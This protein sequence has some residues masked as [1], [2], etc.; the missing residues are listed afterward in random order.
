[1]SREEFE[2][3]PLDQ[4]IALAVEGINE[5]R[6]RE[7][8]SPLTLTARACARAELGRDT[9]VRGGPD[10]AVSMEQE[11]AWQE[12]WGSIVT[13]EQTNPGGSLYNYYLGPQSKG[14]AWADAGISFNEVGI[15]VRSDGES[16]Y[17]I[18]G[19]FH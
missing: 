1:M 9:W 12:Q 18:C 14:I 7:G 6:A 10:W 19:Q 8:Q 17:V 5:S 13:M 15:S 16:C 2:A 3:I 11:K 4:R